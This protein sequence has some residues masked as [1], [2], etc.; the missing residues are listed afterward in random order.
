MSESAWH[1]RVRPTTS[2][3]PCPSCPS[4]SPPCF[5]LRPGCGPLVLNPDVTCVQSDIVQVTS[6]STATPRL[7]SV[8][9]VSVADT[10]PINHKLTSN[11]S[12]SPSVG[13]C[14]S[15]THGPSG[16]GPSSV[17]LPGEMPARCVRMACR[18]RRRC[19]LDLDMAHRR[20]GSPPWAGGRR[21]SRVATVIRS[22]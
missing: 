16:V 19:R 5:L 6:A 18:C 14:L 8:W 9:G 12:Y 2:A 20:T 10:Y 13:M 1:S 4:S 22:V 3:R 17:V 11:V 15:S 7:G 21:S